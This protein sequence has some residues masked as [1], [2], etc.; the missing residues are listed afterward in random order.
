MMEIKNLVSTCNSYYQEKNKTKSTPNADLLSGIAEYITRLFIIFGVYPNFNPLIG[1]NSKSG[2][3]TEEI[4]GPFIATLSN[5]RDSVRLLAQSKADP[6]EFL[7]L[8]DKLRDFDLVEL[9]ISLEDRDDGKALIKMIDKSILLEQRQE[10]F[11]REQEKLQEKEEKKRLL[12]LKNKERLLKGSINPLEMFK[13][14]EYSEWDSNG[15]P[16]LDKDGMEISKSKRKKLEKEY[17]AQ[18][19]LHQEFLKSQH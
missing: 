14:S 11:K 4:V 3:N 7:K 8:C 10:K 6:V 18:V 1:T 19:K 17:H 5:F 2:E 9:G 13:K 16:T 15:I 12:E